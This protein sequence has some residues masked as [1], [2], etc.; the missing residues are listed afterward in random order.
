VN[1]RTATSRYSLFLQYHGIM[2][3]KLEIFGEKPNPAMK[4]TLDQFEK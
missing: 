1:E 4:Y 2:K 3:S